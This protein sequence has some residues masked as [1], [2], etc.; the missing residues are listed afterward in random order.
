[1]TRYR[2]IAETVLQDRN[3]KEYR[4]LKAKGELKGFLD[5]VEQDYRE[6]ERE[7]VLADPKSFVKR[8]QALEMRKLQARE[9][10]IADLVAELSGHSELES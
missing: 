8:S 5:Q 6:K 10:L 4:R 2:E 1:M 7:W 3:P 9:S